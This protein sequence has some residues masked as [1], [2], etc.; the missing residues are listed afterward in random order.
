MKPQTFAIFDTETVGLS[1]K[2]V[3]DLGLII[4]NRAGEPI[5]KKSWLVRE[6]F[7][8]AKLML[9]AFYSHRVFTHYI[10]KIDTQQLRLHSFADI[11]AEFN[12]LMLEHNTKTVCAYNIGF[13]RAAMRETL[14]HCNITE[15]FLT[16]PA[17]FA[18]LWLA[19]CRT[20]ANTNRFRNFCRDNN[21]VSN[22]GNFRTNAQTVFA[23]L[24]QNPAFIESHT[25]LEDCEIETEI[26]GAIS[27]RKRKFPYNEFVAMPWRI[28]QK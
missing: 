12:A 11:R 21:F 4:C 10:P 18:D 20:L 27:K 23:Y 19:S 5:A 26:F 7:T 28:V 17:R 2:L 22:A 3:Y 13:D 15:K 1:P 25:A 16:L 24:K 8:D 9:G 14:A 6:I